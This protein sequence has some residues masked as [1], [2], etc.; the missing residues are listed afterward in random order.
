[1]QHRIACITHRVQSLTT[2]RISARLARSRAY[3]YVIV[4]FGIAYPRVWRWGLNLTDRS[5]RIHQ[6][7]AARRVGRPRRR[8]V[9]NL[10]TADPIE[11]LNGTNGSGD[12]DQVVRAE[13]RESGNPCIRAEPKSIGSGHRT[14]ASGK[15][16]RGRPGSDLCNALNSSHFTSNTGVKTGLNDRFRA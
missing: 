2:R 7:A 1:M 8:S 16:S 10:W 15:H 13:D 12:E 3:R 11:M 6:I 9:V 5:S 4:E 14:P